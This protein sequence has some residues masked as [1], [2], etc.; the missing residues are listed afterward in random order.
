MGRGKLIFD[1][2][3]K[4]GVKFQTIETRP[5]HSLKNALLVE[6]FPANMAI[7]SHQTSSNKIF[8]LFLSEDPP[9]DGVKA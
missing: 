1:T 5:Q 3:L 4:R 2:F 8:Q 6:K 7:S 9:G